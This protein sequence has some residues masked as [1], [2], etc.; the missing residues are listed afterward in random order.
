VELIAH[1]YS[2][3]QPPHCMSVL[4]KLP[5]QSVWLH[6][7]ARTLAVPVMETLPPQ[8]ERKFSMVSAQLDMG[9]MHHTN[10]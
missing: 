4:K 3:L 8:Q 7:V 10:G 1:L 5:L 9:H 2:Q 6:L